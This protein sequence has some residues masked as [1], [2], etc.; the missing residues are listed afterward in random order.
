MQGGGRGSRVSRQLCLLALP[1]LGTKQH[2]F[3][4]LCRR[5]GREG[6]GDGDDDD[7]L[8]HEEVPARD[9]LMSYDVEWDRHAEPI[10]KK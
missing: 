4:S 3:I 2:A 1:F 9:G 7:A 6:A 5:T 10:N 8:A